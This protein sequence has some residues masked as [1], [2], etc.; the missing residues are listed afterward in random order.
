[1]RSSPESTT[2]V[3]KK[4]GVSRNSL[5]PLQ[6]IATRGSGARRGHFAG[7][8]GVARVS[9][10]FRGL[11]RGRLPQA[12]VLARVHT[13]QHARS[14]SIAT[15]APCEAAGDEDRRGSGSS[16]VHAVLLAATGTHQAQTVAPG[17]CRGTGVFGFS[18]GRLSPAVAA[19]RLVPR[20]YG[21]FVRAWLGRRGRRPGARRTVRSCAGAVAPL[22]AVPCLPQGCT[23]GS[24]LRRV[25]VE[26]RGIATPTPPAP[27]PSDAGRPGGLD[28]SGSA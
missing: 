17:A 11:Q 5:N 13:S 18:I 28:G 12:R 10:P 7:S 27:P 15:Q 9:I 4:S 8:R 24:W 25:P 14:P 3:A 20:Q 6:G 16:T 26:G 1:M 19:G 21:S 22:R 2:R 23:A